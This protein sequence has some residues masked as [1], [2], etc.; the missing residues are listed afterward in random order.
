MDN[1]H[2][3]DPAQSYIDAYTLMH[4]SAI[5]VFVSMQSGSHLLAIK[6][7]EKVVRY[8]EEAEHYAR[9]NLFND[10]QKKALKNLMQEIILNFPQ[11]IAFN[12]FRDYFNR[13]RSTEHPF[14]G[15]LKV[16]RQEI[17]RQWY[18]SHSHLNLTASLIFRQCEHP[19]EKK[20]GENTLTL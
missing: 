18:L 15:N 11:H 20:Q 16:F 3:I 13:H 5:P 17:D 8:L 4:Y 2:S 19:A 9:N 7:S 6:C 14:L 12:Y 10:M 1:E